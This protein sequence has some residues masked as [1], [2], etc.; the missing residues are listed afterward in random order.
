MMDIYFL[1]NIKNYTSEKIWQ[2]LAK[3]DINCTFLPKIC[4]IFNYINI[5]TIRKINFIFLFLYQNFFIFAALKLI[6]N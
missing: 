1:Q 4:V 6:K 3:T 2:F 5:L